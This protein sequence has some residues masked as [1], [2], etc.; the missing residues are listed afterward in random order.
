ME[1]KA[2]SRYNRQSPHK[3]R[4]VVDLIR[5]RNVNDA[6][7]ILQYTKKK[8][9]VAIDKTLRSAV[10]NAVDKA[11]Q[12]GEPVDVDELYVKEAFVDEGP[13]YKRW[14]AAAMGRPASIKRPTAHVTVVVDRKE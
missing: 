2:I 11:D 4:L 7:A 9:A 3:M 6:Y 10:A 1:A 8:A 13:Y 12:A 5:G 14:R